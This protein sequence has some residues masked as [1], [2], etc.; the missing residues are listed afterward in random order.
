[1]LT[2]LS[3]SP[4]RIGPLPIVF[5]GGFDPVGAGLVESFNH[6]GGNATGMAMMLGPL[7]SSSRS[8]PA[9]TFHKFRSRNRRRLGSPTR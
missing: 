1:V 3:N 8:N 2:D 9:R 6:P 4:V 5:V 7:G